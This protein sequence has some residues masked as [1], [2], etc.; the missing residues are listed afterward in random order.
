M[1]KSLKSRPINQTKHIKPHE[2]L[3]PDYDS[4]PPVFSLHHLHSDY[5]VSKCMDEEK[6]ALTD[7]LHKLSQLT[8]IQIKTSSRHALGTEKI[9]RTAIRAGV[10]SSITEDVSSFLA[11][12]FQGKKAMVGFRK[13]ATYHIVW[14][15]RDFSLY[16]H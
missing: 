16:Q 15:D 11:F 14:I 4:L 3:Q 7:T 5:C 2:S 10:P 13:Q 12:R 6:V 8:W 1:K 9:R